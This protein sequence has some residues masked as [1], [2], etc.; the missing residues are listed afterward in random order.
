MASIR[1]IVS[2]TEKC[3]AFYR[4]RLGFAVHMQAKGFAALSLSDRRL[5]INQPEAGSAGKSGGN[6]EAGG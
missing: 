6:P 5:F 2:D 1:Y 4:D 3:V